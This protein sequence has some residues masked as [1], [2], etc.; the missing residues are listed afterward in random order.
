MSNN[1]QM[2][3]LPFFLCIILLL[4]A[5]SEKNV[6]P[7][8]HEITL[9]SIS[10]GEERVMSIYLPE[11]Y[12]QS[13]QKYPVLYVLDGEAHFYHASGA[14]NYLSRNGIIPE[15]IV[16]ALINID[17][18]RDFSPIHV[19]NI[20]TSG[21]AEKFL[22][23]ITDELMPHINKIYRTSVYDVL[24]GHS[25]GGVFATYALL[26]K[27]TLFDAY[28]SI[29]PFLQ[30]ADN[31]MVMETK[32]KLKPL[33]EPV[34][35]F[36]TVGSEPAYLDPL[37]KFYDLLMRDVDPNLDFGYEIYNSENHMSNPYISLYKGLRHI[38]RDWMISN[39]T[40]EEGLEAIETYYENISA[41]YGF[42]VIP[43]ENILNNLGYGYMQNNDIENAIVIFK[44]NT[45][46][47]PDSP[48]VYDSLGEAFETNGQLD[49]AKKN[50]KKAYDLAVKQDSPFSGIFQGN[51]ERMK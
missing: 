17:R 45:K 18:N 19:D 27:P 14:V 48:N 4:S 44:A 7:L 11:G 28:I 43:P 46:Y 6:I 15:M 16:V 51:F 31:H 2:K 24:V 40:I 26:E 10:L 37:E 41:K 38:F 29:S 20:P 3:I 33:Q 42:K 50:Y 1:N 36:M 32:K 21:G 34:A 13:I 49:L 8:G 35:F 25:F 9:E 30:F 22:A 23:F 39:E 47:Y 5:C 12:E